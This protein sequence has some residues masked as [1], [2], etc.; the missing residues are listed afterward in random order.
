MG[1]WVGGEV[2]RW[3]GRGREVGSWVGGEVVRR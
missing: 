1:S 3:G 2:G